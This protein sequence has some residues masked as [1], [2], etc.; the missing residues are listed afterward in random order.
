MVS[1]SSTGKLDDKKPP[2]SN[3]ARTLFS[4]GVEITTQWLVIN[5]LVVVVA[6]PKSIGMRNNALPKRSS[7][8]VNLSFLFMTDLLLFPR[9]INRRRSKND[10]VDRNRG[11]S[12]FRRRFLIKERNSGTKF[13][14]RLLCERDFY[15][16]LR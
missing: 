8:K 3:G 10:W 13:N 16:L 14:S 6:L 7:S 4:A 12:S 2:K 11:D 15:E 5:K 1:F 9:Q